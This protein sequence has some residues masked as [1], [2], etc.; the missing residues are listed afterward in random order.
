MRQSISNSNQASISN[1]NQA[2][3]SYKTSPS[4]TAVLHASTLAN[5]LPQNSST[6][7]NLSSTLMNKNLGIEFNQQIEQTEEEEAE[8]LSTASTS[9]RG[10]SKNSDCY[11]YIWL[12]YLMT[13]FLIFSIFL[14]SRLISNEN[15]LTTIQILRQHQD[16]LAKN[17]SNLGDFTSSALVSPKNQQQNNDDTDTPTDLRTNYDWL[18]LWY[19]DKI[20][21]N[22]WNM[23]L[24]NNC[25]FF[26]R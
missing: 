16:S 19:I 24:N 17:Q 4:Q 2:S 14:S 5:L 21:I 10:F 22:I 9:D 23:I 12:I 3:T 18:N 26:N 20:L 7:N 25:F 8:D 6:I 1:S 15:G 13:W 11:K